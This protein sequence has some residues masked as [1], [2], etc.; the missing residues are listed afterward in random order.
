MFTIKVNYNIVGFVKYGYVKKL[1][2]QLMEW[3]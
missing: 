3:R 2:N 1:Y